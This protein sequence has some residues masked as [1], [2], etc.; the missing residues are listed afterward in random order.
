MEMPEAQ[1]QQGNHR[2]VHRRKLLCVR[3]VCERRRQLCP[4]GHERPFSLC[5]CSSATDMDINRRNKMWLI[6]NKRERLQ[7]RKEKKKRNLNRKKTST[8]S[9]S[10]AFCTR[11]IENQAQRDDERYGR[12][13]D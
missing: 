1:Q 6:E 10:F 8:M 9:I 13:A 3:P 4:A 7:E 2:R 11:D 12:R 5:A